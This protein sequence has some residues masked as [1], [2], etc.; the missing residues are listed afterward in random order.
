MRK[1]LTAKDVEWITRQF[2]HP[3]PMYL[4]SE[5]LR[6][7]S[8]DVTQKFLRAALI[9]KQIV[10]ARV[11]KGREHIVEYSRLMSIWPGFWW[12]ARRAWTEARTATDDAA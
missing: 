10:A 9:R 4:I 3:K 1:P 11:G 7:C 12:S 2:K 8:P 6:L 5:L